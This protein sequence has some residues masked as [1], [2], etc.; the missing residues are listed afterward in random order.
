[1]G[2]ADRVVRQHLRTT[3]TVTMKSGRTWRGVLLDADANTLRMADSRLINPDGGETEADGQ[4][5]L[6]RA[7]VDYMQRT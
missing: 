3:F 6:P 7:D 2:R 1:M 5:F 4:V